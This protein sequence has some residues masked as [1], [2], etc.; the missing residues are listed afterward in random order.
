MQVW[1]LTSSHLHSGDVC[2]VLSVI[3]KR[4]E[5][6][7]VFYTYTWHKNIINIYIY[8]YT[9]ENTQIRGTNNNISRKLRLSS[10]RATRPEGTR[11]RW[12]NTSSFLV[13]QFASASPHK[14]EINIY[15]DTGEE[16]FNK[17]AQSNFHFYLILLYEYIHIGTKITS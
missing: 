6:T 15:S 2:D 4:I 7:I 3:I 10:A 12:R 14:H 9:C 11:W 13:Q 16:F 8:L 1:S 17:I 5:T